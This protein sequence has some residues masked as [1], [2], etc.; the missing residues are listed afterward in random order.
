[1]AIASPIYCTGRE[2]W[3]L[4]MPRTVTPADPGFTPGQVSTITH[5][6][7]GTGT[8]A[9]FSGGPTD[10][11]TVTIEV[12]LGGAPGTCT[13]RYRLLPAEAWS[14]TQLIPTG[15]VLELAESGLTVI[16]AGTFVAADTYSFTTVIS[17]QIDMMLHAIS[18]EAARRLRVRGALPL[19]EWGDDLRLIVARLTAHELLALRGFDPRSNHDQMVIA[20]ARLARSK[21]AKIAEE[22][23]QTDLAGQSSTLGVACH[24]QPPQG[25]DLW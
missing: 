14:L 15:G 7:L 22:L 8:V 5:V 10:T 18:G 9:L 25:V 2:L 24:S 20:R 19:A 17:P 4:G 11:Y 12:V 1:M 6:G 3:R 16:L 21:L 23:E 13:V